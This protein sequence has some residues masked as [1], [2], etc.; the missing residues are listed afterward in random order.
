ERKRENKR[1]LPGVKLPPGLKVTASMTTAL[2]RAEVV[3]LA[4]PSKFLRNILVIMKKTGV[5]SKAVIVSVIKGLDII[6]LKRMSETIKGTLQ[7]GNRIAV[8]SGP[9]H[10]EEVGKKVPTAV[11]IASGAIKTSEILQKVF[12]SEYFRV[13]A[14]SDV[15]GVEIGGAVKNVIALAKGVLD[16]LELGDN[17]VA[18]LMTRGLAEI[19]RLAL[20]LG[21]RQETLNGLSGTGDLIVT[22]MSRHS[23]NRAVGERLG[24]GEKLEKI[25]SSMNMVAEGVTTT[26]ACYRLAKRIKVEMPIVNEMYEILFK[27]KDPK[28]AVA[29][30]MGRKLK[31][32]AGI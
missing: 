19:K 30:L 21:A 17:T 7:T 12:S 5:P 20:K 26:K 6:T 27:G 9:S 10:A 11:V 18:A 25:L 16:G 13:Y 23:R 2:H 31:R 1:F 32:E 15:T 28:N 4:V 3:V 22:C 29:K 8:L 24:K 14:S